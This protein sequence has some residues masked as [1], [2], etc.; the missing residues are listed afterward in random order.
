MVKRTRGFVRH[1]LN[2]ETIN[3]IIVSY[4]LG[5]AA[6]KDTMIYAHFSPDHLIESLKLNPL[7]TLKK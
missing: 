6:I 7:A 1:P 4:Q 5:H 2:G 3:E